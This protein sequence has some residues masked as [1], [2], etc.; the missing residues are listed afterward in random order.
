M[1]AN[2]RCKEILFL[3]WSVIEQRRPCAVG[4]PS[5]E[6]CVCTPLSAPSLSSF[7]LSNFRMREIAFH[8]PWDSLI[9]FSS[10][11]NSLHVPSTACSYLFFLSVLFFVQWSRGMLN[12][13]GRDVWSLMS[14]LLMSLSFLDISFP[15]VICPSS[16]PLCRERCRFR[17][18]G[19]W[20]VTWQRG[21]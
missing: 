15:N 2:S 21:D 12:G 14:P 11:A 10:P 7:A 3:G 17:N 16:L 6:K 18:W 13:Y 20:K 4:Q 1:L 9:I 19:V 8:I 5:S